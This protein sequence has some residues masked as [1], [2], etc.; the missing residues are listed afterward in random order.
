MYDKTKH[1]G[2]PAPY[3]GLEH[4]ESN[5]GR[6]L[7]T[8]DKV[9]VK[10]STFSFSNQH[11]LYGRLR[12]YLN[13]VLLPEFS[14]HC[15]SEI[16]PIKPTEKVL[17]EY[18]Y[19]WFIKDDTVQKIN[20]TWT[21]ARMPRANMKEVINFQIPIPP[22]PEQRAIVA[23]LDAA[24]A[25]IAQARANIERNIQNAEEL[26][27]SNLNAVFA[28]R[29]EGS[30]QWRRVLLKEL[31]T[32]DC[33]L[34]YGIVQPGKDIPSGLPVVRPTDMKSK[35]VKFEKLKRIDPQKASSFAKTSLTGEEVLL[36]V[37]GETGKVALIGSEFKG[38]N[39]T[40]GI[41]PIRFDK[42]KVNR[43]FGFYQ[44]RSSYLLDQIKA[45]T[46]GTALMQINVKDARKLVLV[47]PSGLEVQ[48]KIAQEIKSLEERLNFI[49]SM[50]N[51]KLTLL[52][53]LQ[54]SILQRA[55]SGQLTENEVAV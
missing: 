4:I 43:D 27:Q 9:T 17:R 49:T 55:F 12:P 28:G 48:L 47:I 29:G 45:K 44:F 18:L 21:G 30:K 15:S 35:Y 11:L 16:F 1:N 40:R 26:F 7:G 19:Y 46:Y 33:A 6:F 3:V 22:L 20:A 53:E 52:T 38:A 41:I 37:R 14:G 2:T 32:E 39:V 54:Q 51:D 13:K 42:D 31:V 36:C 23:K 8:L 10:S 25:G 24:F 5:T 34:S 50:H